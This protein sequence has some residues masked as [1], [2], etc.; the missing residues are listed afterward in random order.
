MATATPS[1]D[2]SPAASAATNNSR[3]LRDS[4]CLSL[5]T[6]PD[7][8]SFLLK[9]ALTSPHLLES[10]TGFGPTNG[11]LNGNFRKRPRNMSQS[12]STDR[13]MS[14]ETTST[15]PNG[16]PPTSNSANGIEPR[17]T[18]KK[19]PSTD[20]IDYPRRRATIAC[21]ICRSRKSR[22]DG[23]RPKCRLC[24]EL[25]AECVYREPGIKLDAGDKLILE[26][27]NR[28][29][30]LLQTNLANG[31]ALATHSPAASNSTS[32][33]FLA[34]SAGNMAN[35]GAIQPIINGIGTWSTASNISTMPKTHTTAALN[36]LLS[37]MIR[38]L[39]SRP[40]DPKILLQLEMSREP[41]CLGTSLGLDLSNTGAYVQAF[42]ERVNV[43]YACL[44][45]YTWTSYY[46]TALSRGFREGAESC[47]VLLV[48]ALGHAGSMGSISQQSPDK[49]PPGLAYFAA[50]WA[51]LPS[52]MTRNNMLA[53]QC[54]IL[55]SAY[56]VYLAR[57]V[58]AWNVLS[59][60]SMKIQ[61]LL[62]APGRVSPAEEELSKRVY[63]NALM[64]ESDLLAELDLPHSGIESFEDTFTLPTGFEDIGTEPVGRDELWYFLAEIALRRLLNRVSSMLYQRTSNFAKSPAVTSITQLDPLVL[65]LDY[66]LNQ[67]YAGLPPAMQFPLD[68]VPLQNPVQTVLRLR[69]FACRTIIFRPYILLVLQDE[70]LAMDS[71]VQDNCHKCL[72]ACIRQLEYITAHHA[73][74]LP[75]LFQGALSI[76]SQT[77][78]VMGATMCPSLSALL[79][80][81]TTMDDIIANV[82]HEM[83]RLAHLAPSLRLSAELIREAENKRQMWLRTAGLKFDN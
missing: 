13:E 74:H 32:D 76:I 73:G 31:L 80:P 54:Q 57:P 17:A 66:Q 37:P 79:P 15:A 25:N 75:Y 4:F 3:F 56:L 10:P 8:N 40:Y 16:V 47:I 52:L 61:L 33:D 7:A 9:T 22:C 78:L 2:V 68:R 49:D 27:L 45:P 39:V 59:S 6:L 65:E 55:A 21:E 53:A 30:G 44:N 20:T 34:R 48:L 63:W 77:L 41:L 81:P 67:W 24:T 60:A 35:L 1:P 62:S 12:S 36:L 29:E 26:H 23:T 18:A 70:S 43:F 64:M 69:Y 82:I 83:E 19:R 58:E 14:S 38:E 72:E 28:I 50:A 51:L 46:Q 5:S 71:G 11:I 42:F